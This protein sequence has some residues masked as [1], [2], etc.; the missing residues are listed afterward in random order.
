MK[1]AS[2]TVTIVATLLALLTPLGQPAASPAVQGNDWTVSLHGELE[3]IDG[4]FSGELGVWVH[5]ID[6]GR[7]VSWRGD[8]VWY[9]ASGIKVLVAIIALRDVEAGELALDDRLVLQADDFV[10]GAG[11]TNGHP[12][13][14]SLRVDFLLE[15]M[16][17]Y[18]D[19][20]ATDV[21]IRHLGLARIN[22]LAE[23]LMPGHATVTTL[24]DVRRHAYSHFHPGAF[25][26]TSAQLLALRRAAG[27]LA[28]IELLASHLGVARSELALDSLDA[29]F[30]AYYASALN[31]APLSA[32]GGVLAALQDGQ[33]LGPEGTATLLGLL[34][35]IRTGDRRIKAGLPAGSVFAHKTGTQ[36]RRACD[37]GVVSHNGRRLVLAACTRGERGL[38][39]S[40]HALRAVGAA[41]A[42]SGAFDAVVAHDALE[43]DA[44]QPVEAP[45]ASIGTTP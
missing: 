39:G 5:D 7:S 10:D 26:L 42:A 6:S 36:H 13:G 31:A 43:S 37:M 20:T 24:A 12:A 38:A 2:P 28:R 23:Q 17:V 19:N 3:R 4:E 14:S 35:R 16:L 33:A 41:L 30:D 21:L 40:E 22:A 1:I 27:D 9:L 11:Q 8:E 44:L 29:A 45:S 18:S 34:T 32:F 15:Q 25:G